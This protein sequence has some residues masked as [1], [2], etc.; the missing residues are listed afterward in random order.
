[1]HAFIFNFNRNGLAS[2]C[3]AP[4]QGRIEPGLLFLHPKEFFVFL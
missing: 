1:M 3:E 4:L 2:L